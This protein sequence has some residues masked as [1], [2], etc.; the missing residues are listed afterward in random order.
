MVALFACVSL[1]AC[2]DDGSSAASEGGE[3]GAV[4]ESNSSDS[5]PFSSVVQLSSS[6]DVLSS[7]SFTSSSSWSGAIGSSSADS[8][9]A[10]K[11][12]TTKITYALKPF[13]GP[14]SNPHK[15]FTVP[16]GGAWTFVPEFEYGPYGSLNNKAWDL[17]S[18]GSGYQ[19]WYKL[20]PAKGVYDW[21]ELEKLL[22]ALAEHNMTYALRVLPYTP[23]FIKSDFP[24]QEEYDWTPPFVYEMGAK[25][26][27]IDLRGTEYHAY[28]PVWDDS[29][30]IW[31]AKEFAKALAEKY[32]GDPRIEY[33]DV[34]TFGEWGEWHTSHILGSVM[35]ADSVLKDML[36]YYASVFKKTQLV[37]P[38]NGFGDVYT[39]ALNLG[40]TKRDDGFIGIPGRPDTLLRAYNANL[41]TIAENIAG[42]RT[43]LANDDLI[44]GG[45]QKWTAERWVN[46][47]TTAHLTYY[48]LD[49]DNDCGYY[50][51]KDNKAL[52]DSMSK[53]I[54]Y[55]FTVT[56]AE[57]VTV[58]STKDTTSTLNITVKNT[59]VAPCFFDVYMV[60]EF[61]DSTG[62]ALAQIGEMVRIP[63]GTFKDG[64]S[65]E[66]SFTYKVDAG[67]ANVVTQSGVSVA[68][69][70]Y[71]SEDAYK[72]G[73]NPTVRFDND[74]LQGNNKLL[75]KSR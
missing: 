43:M 74:G 50:F 20:N 56:Q 31:A 17:V 8:S 22:N 6:A 35:P 67:Q 18:Y 73:K 72:S 1:V 57:L 51:Y 58:A 49:Q 2:G 59:G 21:T 10:I 9:V 25:K 16:T 45:T 13:D 54:G 47:I 40:I 65:K 36:D 63:K 5:V 61:V 3:S 32:D 55:N 30:Y 66:F 4:E 60:A 37:L 28:A 7:S 29:I 62:K 71:E 15:G 70:L 27:Q 42:Y 23:S 46:A 14:L 48:V 33:I 64:T 24:P 19:Q 53:V 38:S 52:A 75:L 11:A 34:R 39:H 12:D 44:P 41:P 26:I 68:L 69:S